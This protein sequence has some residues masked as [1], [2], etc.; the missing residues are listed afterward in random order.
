VPS[1]GTCGDRATWRREARP[2]R[3]GRAQR[4][5]LWIWPPTAS[6]TSPSVTTG[7]PFGTGSRLPS[8]VVLVATEVASA[9]ADHFTRNRSGSPRRLVRLA[10][11]PPAR[12]IRMS[13]TVASRAERLL[14]GRGARARHATASADQQ[15]RPNLAGFVAWR[16]QRLRGDE[17]GE[18][19]PSSIASSRPSAT[20]ARVS[21]RSGR[22]ERALE[23]LA[24]SSP[25]PQPHPPCT[26]FR[27]RTAS[28]SPPKV[29]RGVA[30]PLTSFLNF[31]AL[32]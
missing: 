2:E 25:L 11:H 32:S 16:Q 5:A 22:F 1:L 3:R 26:R 29:A 27:C 8:G 24:H 28:R 18:P 4:R 19:R 6:G 15:L 10:R 31:Y 7:G 30:S 21:R 23:T 17:K 12:V 20:R 9:T 14:G 13:L